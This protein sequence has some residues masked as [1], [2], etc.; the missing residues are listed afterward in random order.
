[1]Q[2][3][4]WSDPASVSSAELVRMA[5]QLEDRAGR[6]DQRQA[7]ELLL[8]V[9]AA[10]QGERLLEVG[11][12]TGVLCRRLTAPVGRQGRVHGVDLS[13]VLVDEARRL[14]TGRPLAHAAPDRAG[15]ADREVKAGR[16]PQFGVARAEALP[17][18]TA[19]FDGAF[20]A[21]LLLHM[22][23]AQAAVNEMARVVRPG[24]RVALLEWDWETV[25]VDHPDRELTRRILRWRCDHE[26]TDN[27]RGRQLLGLAG[28]AGLKGV[29][30]KALAVV[31]RDDSAAL[32][33][34]LW[35]VAENARDA[36]AITEAEHHTWAVDLRRRIAEERFCASIVYFVVR[37]EA[38]EAP[39]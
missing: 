25:A 27:W 34:S 37:G 26:G 31:A 22:T 33:L 17:F 32:T 14:A 18:A 11:C 4:P 23:A 28:A 29:E 6:P 9:L 36:G 30:V 12:G 2:R 13:P 21:R 19:S 10:R 38:G 7:N 3:D 8:E 20:A 15:R 39:D 35:R 16:N 1:M 5:A 24:G